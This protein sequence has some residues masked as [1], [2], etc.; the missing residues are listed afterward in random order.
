[1]KRKRSSR[2][3]VYAVPG[4]RAVL[5]LLDAAPGRVRRLLVSRTFPGLAE[6]AGRIAI[7]RV[8]PEQLRELA[9]GAD[10]RGIVALADPPPLRAIDEL[11][12]LALASAGRRKLLVALDGL[13]D[14]HNVGAIARSCEFFGVSGMFWPRDRAC[15]LTPAVARASAGASERLPLCEVVNLADALRRCKDAGLW[16]VG[17]VVDGGQ[18]LDRMCADDRLPNELVLVLGSESSGLRR[19]TADRCDYL[20]TLPRAGRIGSLNVS[21]AAA[22]TLAILTTFA[23]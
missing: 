10:P 2:P 12:D 11:V 5:E 20:V 22:A 4:E 13:Q 7:E 17:T 18:S 6:A 19:L 3:P 23:D 21:A 9:D 14:P 8:D 16:A 1:M 15:P